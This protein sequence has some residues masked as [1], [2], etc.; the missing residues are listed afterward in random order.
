MS[1]SSQPP[2][3]SSSCAAIA[4]SVRSSP[5]RAI[6]L[7]SDGE[8]GVRAHHGHGECGQAERARVGAERELAARARRFAVDGWE[9]ED[10]DG[11]G[12]VER[13]GA[14]RELDE[15]G[16]RRSVPFHRTRTPA[17]TVKH[18]VDEWLE[19][20]GRGFGH[21]D[22]LRCP[23]HPRCR[24]PAFRLRA[25]TKVD[26][27]SRGR[28]VS[29]PSRT[30]RERAQRRRRLPGLVRCGR[31]V[32]VR[33]GACISSSVE[34]CAIAR[35]PSPLF[36]DAGRVRDPDRAAARAGRSGR[37][38]GLDGKPRC[39]PRLSTRHRNARKA[40]IARRAQAGAAG[41]APFRSPSPF[42]R[43]CRAKAQRNHNPRVGGSSPSSGM[44]SAC[45][46]A[47]SAQDGHAECI[48]RSLAY[49]PSGFGSV[50]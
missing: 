40:G 27:G 2:S 43:C 6:Q 5:R 41:I 30:L 22:A 47:L 49:S 32:R 42:K 50:P 3:A 48:P 13:D 12:D 38:V 44:I 20:A 4:I 37:P 1:G 35:A 25:R 10:P 19:E 24:R 31:Q 9:R 17:T 16:H 26:Q 28:A 36:H 7:H 18:L 45:K 15:I 33:G 21:R 11:R 39:S 14:Q 23:T 46:M 29:P 8:L 34:T